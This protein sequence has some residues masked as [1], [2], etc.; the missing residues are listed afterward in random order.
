MPRLSLP[1]L[2]VGTAAV[3][4]LGVAAGTALPQDAPP[5][6]PTDPTEPTEQT[7]HRPSPPDPGASS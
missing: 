7:E 3:L 5:A 1:A 2:A 6:D 4:A